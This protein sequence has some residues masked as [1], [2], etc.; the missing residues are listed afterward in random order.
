M[1]EDESD[2]PLAAS[3]DG[4]SDWILDSKSSYHLCI[5]RE[6]FSTYATCEG[7]VRMVNNTANRVV[8]KGTIRFCMADGRSLTLTKERHIPRLRKNLISIGML[9]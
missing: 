2:V 4:K 5:D 9:D 1:A 8:D 7:L 6:M 3:A